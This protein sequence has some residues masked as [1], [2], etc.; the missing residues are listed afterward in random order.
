MVAS[1]NGLWISSVR[2]KNT[3]VTVENIQVYIRLEYSCRIFISEYVNR[4][5]YHGFRPLHKQLRKI[6]FIKFVLLRVTYSMNRVILP[7][8]FIIPYVIPLCGLAPPLNG[9]GSWKIDISILLFTF[10]DICIPLNYCN[11]LLLNDCLLIIRMII[12]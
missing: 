3:N 12:K 9:D 2:G 10:C 5:F 6:D 1:S 7:T 8:I 11:I 4:H